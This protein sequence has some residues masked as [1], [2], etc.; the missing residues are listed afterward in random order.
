MPGQDVLNQISLEFG[1]PAFKDISIVDGQC[2]EGFTPLFTTKWQT[3]EGCQVND[4][5]GY[6]DIWSWDYL[7]RYNKIY[8][9]DFYLK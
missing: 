3:F 1:S 6:E 8:I 9:K 2:P 7:V 5:K 4:G